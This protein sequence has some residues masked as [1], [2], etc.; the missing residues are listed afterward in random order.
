MKL[1]RQ[2]INVVGCMIPIAVTGSLLFST[3]LTLFVVPSLY[4]LLAKY[5][6]RR[7]LKKELPSA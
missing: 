6:L 3:L 7:K 2:P 1:K 4:M 5:K